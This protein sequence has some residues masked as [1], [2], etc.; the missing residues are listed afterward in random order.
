MTQATAIVARTLGVAEDLVRER[1]TQDTVEGLSR[2]LL[3]RAPGAPVR[4]LRCFAGTALPKVPH[5]VRRSATSVAKRLRQALR[6]DDTWHVADLPFVELG[7]QLE[8]VARTNTG[9]TELSHDVDWPS[10]YAYVEKLAALE[11]ARGVRSTFLFLA[12]DGYTVDRRLVQDLAARGFGIGVHGWTH[13][14]AIGWRDP[15]RVREGLAR[16]RE[17][18]G[19]EAKIYRAPGLGASER[20]FQVLEELG[21]E[22]DGSL[23][24]RATGTVLP[25]EVPGWSLREHPLALQD[26]QLFRDR[27][28]DDRAALEVAR[29][30]L[31][32]VLAARGSFVFNGHPTLLA[33]HPRFYEEFLDHAKARGPVVPF[34]TPLA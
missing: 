11:Q 31:D 21:F 5:A 18:L 20:L 23:T 25:Y 8:P 26:D 6:G 3:P 9:R 2:R 16:A 24:V 12:H 7:R 30:L 15:V 28:L 17:A 29:A 33:E 32:E 1:V 34:G 13:D 4:L 14:V 22:V 10:C 19:V 27:R